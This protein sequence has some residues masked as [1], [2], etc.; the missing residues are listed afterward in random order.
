MPSVMLVHLGL[1]E[2]GSLPDDTPLFTLAGV[3][4]YHPDALRNVVKRA[5]LRSGKRLRKPRHATSE[6]KWSSSSRRFQVDVLTRIAQAEADVYTLTVRKAGRRIEDTPENYAVLIC[7][8]LQACWT[9]HPNVAL[10]IDRRFTSPAHVAA[11]NTFIYRQWP[12]GGILSIS[13]VDSQRNP[14]VQLADF[15]AGCVYAFHKEGD[16][17]L[18]IIESRVSAAVVAEWP[19]IKQRWM[20]KAK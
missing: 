17:M 16:N 7:E 14:L 12:A 8:L 18:K 5:A 2:S 3:L 15:V 4:T 20:S 9:T 13:H 1:D 6:F 10:A 19:E 11:L